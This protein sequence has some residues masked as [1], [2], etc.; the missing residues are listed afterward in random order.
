MALVVA[1][2]FGSEALGNYGYALALT[3]V[4]LIVPDFGLHLFAVRELSATPRRLSEIFWGVHWL[5]FGLAVSVLIFT[6]GFGAWGITDRERRL[7]FYILVA[8][9]LLQ[10]FS[11]AA[12]AIFKAVER[13]QYVAFQQSINSL[14]IVVWVG[15]SLAL[16][17]RLPVLVAGLVA[18]QLAETCLGWNIL[19]KM[20]PAPRF[21]PPDRTVLVRIVTGCLP[22]G[23]T[24]V[25]LALSLRIDIFVL[26]HY[27]TTRALGQ[28]NAA[29]WFVIA[30][31]LV[32]SLLMSVL[33]PKLSRLLTDSSDRAGDYVL[34]LV[35]NALLI[36]GFGALLVWLSAPGL[37]SLFF[38]PD[39]ALAADTLRILAPALPLVFLN[40]VF[41]YVFAA[42][43]RRFVCLGTLTL[44]VAGGT[45]LSFYMTSRYGA[46]GCAAAAVA[47]EFT[48]SSI[49]VLFLTQSRHA[50]SAGLAL[51]K[52]FVGATGFL[53]TAVL[54]AAPLHLASLWLAAWTVLVLAGTIGVLGLPNIGEWRLL[55][56]DRL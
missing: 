45:L 41:F 24:A 18:G 8:R 37:I 53:A 42:A 34:S 55:T 36:T 30:T 23:I 28:F 19:R 47:R 43:R 10:T 38:G 49:Y 29:V 40:T 7:L 44:G 9:V 31:F 1:R 21:L 54:F 35:K 48:I 25:L 3:S 5:K 52:V 50:R 51:M 6:V 16:R 26:S 15:V 14:V 17:A 4:L 2:S 56:D 12:M 20:L 32:A 33:F 11:Q 13:M 27:V 39:F 46:A 22:I